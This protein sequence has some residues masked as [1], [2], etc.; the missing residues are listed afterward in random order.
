MKVKYKKIDVNTK[1]ACLMQVTKCKVTKVLNMRKILLTAWVLS[2]GSLFIY[3]L[4]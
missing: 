1:I 3:S 4:F 2:I